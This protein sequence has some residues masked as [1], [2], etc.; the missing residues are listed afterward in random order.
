M[1]DLVEQERLLNERIDKS[2]GFSILKS[3]RYGIMGCSEVPIRYFD[4]WVKAEDYLYEVYVSKEHS[5]YWIKDF[6]ND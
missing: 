5:G 2:R 6:E 3:G 1:I 4:D